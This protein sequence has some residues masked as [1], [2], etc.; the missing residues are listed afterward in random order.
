M[1]VT[2]DRIWIPLTSWIP[3]WPAGLF[4]APALDDVGIVDYETGSSENGLSVACTLAFAS[5]LAFGIPGVDAVELLL[6]SDGE[7]TRLTVEAV[8]GAELVVTLRDL[9]AS[10]RFDSGLLRPVERDDA[11]APWQP[12]V[13]I[14]GS[15]PQLV[16]TFDAGS[17][18]VDGKGSVVLEPE[19]AVV[20][21][22]F[23]IGETGIV[24]EA[25]GVRLVLGGGEPPAGQVPGFRG[26]SI[27]SATLYLPPAFA[28]DIA[29]DSIA[30]T[31]LVIGT[32]G[33]SGTLTGSWAPTWSGT[34]P[35]GDGA[36]TLGGL[37]FA[38]EALS[39]ELAQNAI[40]GASL[41]GRLAVPFFDQVLD[42][43]VTIGVDGTIGLAVRA[44]DDS[45]DGLVTLSVPGLGSLAVASIGLVSDDE[46]VGLVLSG[47]L[48]PELGSPALQWPTVALQELRIDADGSIDVAGGWLTLQQP[49]ALDLYGF[50]ME[51]HPHRLRQR[52]G[53]P[54]LVRRRR[55]RAPAPSRCRRRVRARAAR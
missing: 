33:V 37:A 32:G 42:V 9:R 19:P 20:L 12:V 47:D 18:T 40:V 44:A 46:G 38:L 13:S 52:G 4:T 21:E 29:P 28:L 54:P 1:T 53:R 10:L 22:P 51:T 23:E 39:L 15:T 45:T 27:D 41:T 14:D 49:L 35:S 8:L 2:A 17:A 36:G 7:D 5:D 43:E 3:A 30:A 31:G 25:S 26:V 48:Q 6:L 34:T 24:V 50:G 55:R 11:S 16:A